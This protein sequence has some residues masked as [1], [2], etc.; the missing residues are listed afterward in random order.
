M[1]YKIA[2]AVLLCITSAA[3]AA[4]TSSVAPANL[5]FSDLGGGLIPFALNNG[6][7]VGEFCCQTSADPQV[8][9]TVGFLLNRAGSIPQ[10]L[11]MLPPGG[12]SA[13][14]TGIDTG[15]NTVV[16]GYCDIGCSSYVAQHGFYFTVDYLDW[17]FAFTQIDFPGAQATIANGVNSSSVIVGVYCLKS[18]SCYFQGPDHGFRYEKGVF[19]EITFPGAT[20]TG[21]FGINTAGDMVG[22]YGLGGPLFRLPSRGSSGSLGR[23]PSSAVALAEIN[24][25]GVPVYGWVYSGGA[26]TSINPPGSIATYPAGINNSGVVVGTFVDAANRQ[27]GFTY[28][29]GVFRQIDHP[30]AAWTTADGI[31]DKNEIVGTYESTN[32]FSSGYTAK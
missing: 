21:V 23:S 9:N 31:N 25:N 14:A 2:V 7:V 3:L 27:H 29:G 32:G 16:G 17:Y 6:S 30:N 26:Y 19:A 11:A 22:G 10:L 12:S 5:A 4:Q 8:L 24:K 1:T 28:H 15:G 18:S 20:S 13:L